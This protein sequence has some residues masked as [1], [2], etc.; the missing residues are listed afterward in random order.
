MQVG[1]G[2]G[3]NF[4]TA[5]EKSRQ[6]DQCTGLNK[7]F[8]PEGLLRQGVEQVEKSGYHAE[9]VETQSTAEQDNIDI[10]HE[11]LCNSFSN[12]IWLLNLGQ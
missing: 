1:D 5:A 9:R 6:V 4:D 3:L 7:A 12:L 8:A 10:S 2:Q 11:K